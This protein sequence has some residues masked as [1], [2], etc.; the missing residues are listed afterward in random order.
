MYA[1]ARARPRPRARWEARYDA[2]K[3]DE[4]KALG[5]T[6]GLHAQVV[7]VAGSQSVELHSAAGQSGAPLVG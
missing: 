2:S 1:R 4:G 6:A 5:T 7:P 3:M